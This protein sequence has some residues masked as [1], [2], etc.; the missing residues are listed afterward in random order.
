MSTGIKLKLKI[1]GHALAPRPAGLPENSAPPPPSHALGGSSLPAA[2]GHEQHKEKKRKKKRHREEGDGPARPSGANGPS[3]ASHAFGASRESW[4]HHTLVA[5]S[6]APLHA[7]ASLTCTLSQQ[8]RRA[9]HTLKGRRPRPSDLRSRASRGRRAQALRRRRSTTAG[10]RTSRARRRSGRRSATVAA[11][12]Q[13]LVAAPHRSSMLRYRSCG[14]S[15]A[16]AA[17]TS[18]WLR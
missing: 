13:L 15:P 1:G 12:L 10:Q 4:R 16:L 6:V 5:V 11:P 14:S 9:A 8:G 3:S 18:S 2:T 7:R 17:G